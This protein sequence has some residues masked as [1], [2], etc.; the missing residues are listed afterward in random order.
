MRGGVGCGLGGPGEI[1]ES[2][3]CLQMYL[4]CALMHSF[5]SHRPVAWPV[6]MATHPPFI[7]AGGKRMSQERRG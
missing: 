5:T 2:L 3:S 4:A 6:A 7:G 1:E